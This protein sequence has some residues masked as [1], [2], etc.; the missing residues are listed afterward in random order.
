MFVKFRKAPLGWVSGVLGHQG[1][2]FVKKTDFAEFPVAPGY[3]KSYTLLLDQY[4][5]NPNLDFRQILQRYPWWALERQ[6]R[7]FAQIKNLPNLPELPLA[8]G[9]PLRFARP[10]LGGATSDRCKNS[11]NASGA[12]KAK[13]RKNLKFAKL[14]L[15]WPLAMRNPTHVA[16][17]ILGGAKCG[18]SLD[19]A[20]CP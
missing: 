11:R 13:V 17:P 3:E 20:M 4:S 9:N 10:I 12:Q 18:L 8:T 2:N 7:N 16:R 19:F 14:Y 1:C 6:R 5:W 15:R